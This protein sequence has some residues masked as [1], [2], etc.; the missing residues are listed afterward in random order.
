L[1]DV[2]GDTLL[3]PVWAA[4]PGRDLGAEV[5]AGPSFHDVEELLTDGAV[6][7]HATGSDLE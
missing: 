6:I 2:H 7:Q 1:A 4:G 5:L 3:I